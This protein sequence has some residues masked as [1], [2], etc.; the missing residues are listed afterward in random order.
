MWSA[1]NKTK[2]TPT[3]DIPSFHSDYQKWVNFKDLFEETIHKN[4]SI[5]TVQKLQLLKSKVKGEAEKLIQHLNIS[6][7]NYQ[8]GWDIHNHRYN[9][10]NKIFSSHVNTLISMPVMQ[11]QT[12]PQ[13][14]KI[15]DTT[16]ECL[17]AVT[18]LGVDVTTWDPLL[19]HIICLKLDTETHKQYIKSLYSPREL[20][21][22]AD[23]F[24][25]LENKFTSLEA[26]R[27][28]QASFVVIQYKE[29]VS[30]E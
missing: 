19:V 5:S 14:K 27:G 28:K 8:A 11:Q 6:S 12:A 25:F 17:N 7:E 24:E 18:N 22:L 23:F 21:S 2:T 29:N 13:I 26:S 30:T 16:K 10:K 15:H 9:N 3:V 20:P 4:R 1:S